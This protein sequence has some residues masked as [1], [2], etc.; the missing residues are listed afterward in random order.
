MP[1]KGK[2]EGAFPVNVQIS[3]QDPLLGQAL[4]HYLIVERIGAGGMGVVYRAYDEHLDRQVAIKVIRHRSTLDEHARKLLHKEALVLS[5]LNHPNIAT[6]YDFDTQQGLDFLVM[7]FVSGDT[8]SQRLSASALSEMEVIALGAQIALALQEAHEHGIIHRDLKPANIAITGKG[9][10]KVLDFGLAKMFDPTRGDLNAETLTQSVD[11]AELAGTLPYMAPEQIMGAHVDTRTDIFA[12][13]VVF[14][15]MV[16]RQRAFR[17]DTTPQVFA[18][19]L[20]QAVP[21]PRTINPRISSE[22]ERII[23]KCTEKE[24]ENRY[25]SAKELALDFKRLATLS[26]AVLSS[27]PQRTRPSLR[28][29]A[30]S[31]GLI[32]ILGLV[33]LALLTRSR[34]AQALTIHD[35]VVLGDFVNTT[36][37]PVFDETLRTALGIE[38]RQS[39]FL[40]VLSDRKASA[41]LQMMGR[42][43]DTRLIGD[44]GCEACLRTGS[45]ALL[46][47][48][49]SSMGNHYVIG[50][51]AVA[52][53]SGDTLVKEQAEASNKEQVLEVLSRA[54][55]RLR[56]RL[57][58]SLPSIQKFDVP[59]EATTTSLEALKNYSMGIRVGHEQ[60]NAPSIPFLKRAVELDPNFAMAYA[61]LAVVSGNLHQSSSQLEYATKAYQLRD[62]VSEHEKYHISAFY[63]SATGELEKE[64]EIYELWLANYPRDPTPRGNLAVNYVYLGQYEKALALQQETLR[65]SPDDVISYADLGLSYILL[66]HLDEAQAVF[67]QAFVHKLDSASLRESIY[68][69]AFLRGDAKKMAEQVA[70]AAGKPGD[71]DPFLS[72]QSD[73]EA[74]YGRLDKARDFS[75][76]AVDSA[77]RADSKEAAALW[78]VNAA[79]REAELGNAALAR[80]GVRKALQLSPGREVKVIGALALARNG[81]SW[82]AKMLVQNLQKDLADTMV[83]LYW[84]P[85]INA[86]IELDNGN[87]SQALMDLEAA[88]PYELGGAGMFINDLYPVFIRGRAYLQAGQATAAAVEFEKM[89]DHKSIVGN[90]VIGSLAH[91]Q[92]ARA[93][94]MSGDTTKAKAGYQDFLSLWKDADPDIAILKEAKVEY[95]KLR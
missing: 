50:L 48:T 5:K 2:E 85:T 30:I 6:I 58:E 59:V 40:N 60:G 26:A 55:S 62:R 23:Q 25:Q 45:K 90:F 7:E 13:G 70:W 41:A 27:K 94:A 12:A 20:H 9:N 21:A 92:L 78:Q 10:A 15:E 88:A 49:I 57:G 22:L 32:A 31:A 47:G 33:V 95:A 16:T 42:P 93:Y 3:G 53:G 36:G 89:L 72:V 87:P 69:L 17:G 19:I 38:L 76:R 24:P 8:V 37:D 75:R 73:T 34:S 79:L 64:T 68:L 56:N 91:L 54:A 61:Q 82:R 43:A 66:N 46:G 51:N 18:S 29:S 52:C 83:R 1:P 86:S 28:K 80:Q 65:L 63:F 84:L 35:T 77:V 4:G 14:Y 81:D 74:Y 71:E 11:D 39:P 67:D 44:V